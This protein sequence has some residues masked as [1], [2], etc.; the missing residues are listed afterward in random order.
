MLTT[1]QSKKLLSAGVLLGRAG[2]VLSDFEAD[3]VVTVSARFVERK[4]ET[5]VTA[6]EWLVLDAAIDAMRL[7]VDASVAAAEAA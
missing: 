6:A 5:V 7:V 1:E 3:L 2:D 4:G